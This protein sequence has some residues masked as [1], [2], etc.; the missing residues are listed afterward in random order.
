MSLKQQLIDAMKEAM[1]AKASERLSTIRLIRSAIKN[2]EID[3]REELDDQEVIAI[4]GTLVKQRKESA[5]VYR[6]NQRP[7]LAEKE[8]AELQILQEFLPEPLSEGE[9]VAL[10]DE[11]VAE[12]GASS[13]RD[14]GPVMK[15]V[16]ERALGRAD[17]KQA[18]QL[19]KA[20]LAG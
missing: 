3:T 5:Q 9:L 6:D 18:S 7:E 2:R 10:I 11:I 1:K 13:M 12:L 20:R 17:G 16:G 14:M 19:V 4:L 15:L 8:E